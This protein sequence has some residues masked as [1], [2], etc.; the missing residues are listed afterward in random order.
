M[1]KSPS[2]RKNPSAEILF[3]RPGRNGVVGARE[4][5]TVPRP[6]WKVQ[7]IAVMS[8][9][10]KILAGIRAS[11]HQV[12]ARLR[13]RWNGRL[14]REASRCRT[15]SRVLNDPSLCRARPARKLRGPA[16]PAACAMACRGVAACLGALASQ[17]MPL[18][19]GAARAAILWPSFAATGR[20][21]A[22]PT[23]MCKRPA[24]GRRA[25]WLEIQ[26]PAASATAGLPA[27]VPTEKRGSRRPLSQ[28]RPPQSGLPRAG[29][30]S[31]Q[32]WPK[33]AGRGHRKAARL[34]RETAPEGL[35]ALH[36][37]RSR[38]PRTRRTSLARC[39]RGW[40]RWRDE[41]MTSRPASQ[42]LESAPAA[43]SQR[44]PVGESGLAPISPRSPAR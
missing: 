6:A 16:L 21:W 27:M 3:G 26:G 10:R 2:G 25:G 13:S 12:G 19:P 32:R 5:S 23:S 29:G 42:Q 41:F 30:I 18:S 37:L 28:P 4:G 34:G 40:W 9:A 24:P 38:C 31:S 1:E 43:G 8:S 14:H 17:A 15:P 33:I 20:G 39:Q 11:S 36:W 22:H 44:F 7:A 35:R